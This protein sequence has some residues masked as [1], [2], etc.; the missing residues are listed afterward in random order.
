[1]NIVDSEKTTTA[2]IEAYEAMKL[3]D[4]DRFHDAI[5]KCHKALDRFGSNRNCYLVKARAHIHQEEYG[6]A[7]QA[8]QAVL[9]IDPEHPAAWVMLGEVYFRLGHESKVDYCRSRLENIFP[10]LIEFLEQA[11]ESADAIDETEL[12]EEVYDD[13]GIS[14]QTRQDDENRLSVESEP[15]MPSEQ[16]TDIMAEDKDE[17]IVPLEDINRGTLKHN[18]L[19]EGSEISGKDENESGQVNV[20]KPDIFE[21]A[22][23][24]DICF[25]QGKYDKAI[26]VYR[27]LLD[28]DPDNATYK[29]KLRI[30]ESKMGLK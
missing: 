4:S 23:F 26:Q 16:S 24:A 6:F 8:L 10:A 22:T 13:R 18:D 9:Q 29:E 14:G 11:E 7:E 19:D 28:N 15:D 2:D 20:I 27:K 30:I 1:M 21:T 12:G 25:S 3:L 17:S 5:D